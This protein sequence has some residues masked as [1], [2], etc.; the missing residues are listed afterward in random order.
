MTTHK[1]CF[2]GEI[3]K[4]SAFFGWKKRLICCYEDVELTALENTFSYYQLKRTNSPSLSCFRSIF[5][6]STV[7]GGC[8]GGTG[9]I[10]VT[11]SCLGGG[12]NIDTM[13]VLKFPTPKC[14]TKWHM[15]TV[16]TQISLIRVYTVCHSMK[17]FKKQLHK[18]H[19]LGWNSME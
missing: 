19:N 1:I 14:L 9:G 15:Q 5:F 6:S 17:Y 4:I 2:H 8:S 13:N 11:D 12:Y 3:R 16:Q 10:F 7:A 18:K